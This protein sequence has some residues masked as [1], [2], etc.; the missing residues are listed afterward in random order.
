VAETTRGETRFDGVR[1]LI[2]SAIVEESLP[3]LAVAV[4]RDGQILWEEGFGWADREART[5]AT[6]QTMYSL[7]SI[8]KPITATGIMRL[9]EEKKLDLDRP[10]NDY[11]G[12]AKL[13]AHVG[14]AADATVRRVANH[15]SGLCLHY[16]FFPENEPHRRPSM[17]ETILRYGH[18]V[19]APGE[20]YYYSNLGYGLLDHL[21]ARLSGQTY[22]DFL[23]SQ[24]FLPLGMTRASVN[25]PPELSPYTAAR[26]GHD[27]A[28]LPFYDFDHPGGSAIWCSAHDLLRFG[29]FHLGTPLPDQKAILP[30]AAR[31]AMQAPTVSQDE[32][33][34]YGVGWSSNSDDRGYRIV[35]HG[36]GM[37]GVSTSLIL[38]PSERIV[39]VSLGNASR[40]LPYRITED[41]LAALLPPYADRLAADRAEAKE[42]EGAPAPETPA[43]QTPPELAGAWTGTIHTYQGERSLRLW[44][45]ESGDIHA[46]VGEGPKALLDEVRLEKGVL[47]GRMLGD[48]G[49]EDAS[50][51]RHHLHLDL[52]PRGETLN[53][54]TIAITA[55][56][57]WI[58]NALSHW[59]ELKKAARSS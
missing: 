53:G 5:P 21:I 55:P 49:T 59:T 58:G 2:R 14:D 37:A 51:H 16:H 4:A 13:T 8:S 45:R 54:A 9:V 39:V 23:R 57:R 6:A 31:E 56:G 47:K 27:G 12:M 34:G 1:A 17:D 32:K 24:V 25:P 19:A 11:L 43:F 42:K 35:A 52:Q 22:P 28:R 15:T 30:D 26:Y 40:G 33:H 46:Q 18:L 29:M 41:L 38:V 20:R 44:F 50:R 7:A 48:L 3:S 36:G 10:I